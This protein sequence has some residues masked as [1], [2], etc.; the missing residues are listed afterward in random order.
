MVDNSNK[1]TA[2]EFYS[3]ERHIEK[4]KTKRLIKNLNETRG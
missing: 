4:W 3:D 2:S 1:Q